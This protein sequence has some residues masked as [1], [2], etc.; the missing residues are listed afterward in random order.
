MFTTY[1]AEH[2]T[3]TFDMEKAS[4][5]LYASDL[6]FLIGNLLHCAELHTM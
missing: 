1:N 2:A 3:V 6:E 5:T 4:L